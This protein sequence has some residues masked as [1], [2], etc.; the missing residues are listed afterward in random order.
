MN[1]LAT[2][3]TKRTLRF[4]VPAAIHWCGALLAVGLLA[5]FLF[6]HR[7]AERDLWSSHEARAAQNAQ[8]ILNDG[9][10]LLPHQFDGHPEFQKPPLYY[11]SVAA[12][13]WL[14]GGP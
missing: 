6:L 4:P 9:S 12:T 8:S 1:A 3:F 14:R 7:L 5:S 13:A 10:W 11:W 2:E